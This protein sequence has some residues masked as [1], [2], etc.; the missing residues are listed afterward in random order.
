MNKFKKGVEVTRELP[1]EEIRGFLEKVNQ[2]KA[3]DLQKR[4]TYMIDLET[5]ERMDRLSQGQRGF[6]VWLVNEALKEKLDRLEA[7]MTADR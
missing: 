5:I 3:Q 1:G 7:E 4:Q 2:P 6:K